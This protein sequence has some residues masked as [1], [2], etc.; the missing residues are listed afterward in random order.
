MAKKLSLMRY[1]GGVLKVTLFIFL[2]GFAVKNSEVVTLR[3][4]LG[5]EWSMPLI[6]VILIFFVIGASL[7]AAASLTYLFRQRRELLTLRM[8]VAKFNESKGDQHG[9]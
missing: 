3:Y 4:Y 1:I 5:Y 2:L 7:G 8:V 9:I 6:L